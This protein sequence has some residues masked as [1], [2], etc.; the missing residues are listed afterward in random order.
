MR[1]VMDRGADLP[2]PEAVRGIQRLSDPLFNRGT[3]FTR[4]AR[5]RLGIEGLLPPRVETLDEQVARALANLRGKAGPL[6]KYC[7]LSALRDANETLFCRIALDHLEELLPII[8]T[9]TVGEA[10]LAWCSIYERPRGLYL[11]AAQHRGHVAQLLR[12][13]PHRRV[14]IIVITDG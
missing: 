13:W 11:S 10:C 3:A 5:A 1:I 7:Y 8:Y 14:G 4:A 9:P 12:N 6:E 2:G